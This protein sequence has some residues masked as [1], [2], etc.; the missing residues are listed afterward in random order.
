MFFSQADL[1]WIDGFAILEGNWAAG[2]K[3]ATGWYND[4]IRGF[5]LQD[6][7]FFTQAWVGHRHN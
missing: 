5:T 1:R 2:V 4:G 6:E 3:A 7:A